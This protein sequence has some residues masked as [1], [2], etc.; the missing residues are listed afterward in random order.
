[1]QFKSEAF[2]NFDIQKTTA[3]YCILEYILY[4]ITL[5]FQSFTRKPFADVLTKCWIKEAIYEWVDD[6]IQH[7]YFTKNDKQ[8]CFVVRQV[9]PKCFV[10]CF[11]QDKGPGWEETNNADNEYNQEH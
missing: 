11:K 10:S 9:V 5:R 6:K 3:H 8:L 1:M 2:N 4:A 7:K